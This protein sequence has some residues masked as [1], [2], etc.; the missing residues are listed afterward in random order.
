MGGGALLD[1]IHELDLIN[2]I[3]G[4]VKSVQANLSKVSDLEINA[5]DLVNLIL[6]NE[7]GSV[8]QV[9]MDM[10]SPVYRRQFEIVF[11]KGIF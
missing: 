2:W 9:Q 4:P 7:N 3:I 1:L 8:G 10:L 11:K 6:V 5:E